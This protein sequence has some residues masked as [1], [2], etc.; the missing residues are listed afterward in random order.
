MRAAFSLEFYRGKRVLV[1]G[2]TGFKGA[3]LCHILKKLGATVLGYAK[4]PPT[5]PSLYEVAHVGD[6]MRS[7]LADIRDFDTLYGAFCDFQPQIVFH[8]AAQPIVREGYKQPLATFDTNVMGTVNVLEC[9]RLADSVRSAV[10]VTTDKVYENAGEGVLSESDR[11]GGS[12]PYSASKS[13]AELVVQSYKRS[14]F[15]SERV[16]LST[17]RAGNVIG[18]GDF[19]PNRILPDLVRGVL[20]G[21]ETL[22]RNPDAVRPYQHVLEPLF[23]YLML[24]ERQQAQPQL[25]GCYNIGPAACDC[26]TTEALAQ[27]LSAELEGVRWRNCPDDGMKEAKTLRLD[28]SKLEAAFSWRPTWDVAQA[29]AHTAAWTRAYAAGEDVTRVMDAQIEEF[30]NA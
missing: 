23:A 6:G 13:C 17:V 7:V 1:T 11:L 16:A 28:C 4:K 29:V 26:V 30:I 5:T 18:G 12:D 27:L 21:D 19:A 22:L 3:W 14:F 8:L 24:A 9:I 15:A 10:I 20:A 25:A 2:H